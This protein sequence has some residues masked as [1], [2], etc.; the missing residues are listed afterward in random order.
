[1]LLA[2]NSHLFPPSILASACLFVSAISNEEA[3]PN[4]NNEKLKSAKQLFGKWF[5]MQQFKECVDHVRQS[6]AESRHNP[7]FSRFDAVNNKYE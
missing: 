4:E 6:W 5:T 2:V 3:L 7:H 1:M